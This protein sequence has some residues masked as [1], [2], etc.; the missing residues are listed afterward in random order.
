LFYFASTCWPKEASDI[1][2]TIKDVM[3][4]TVELAVRFS[5]RT[6]CKRCSTGAYKRRFGLL[7]PLPI[8]LL[9]YICEITSLSWK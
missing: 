1:V 8:W 2:S 6:Q 3:P 5:L 9:V 7:S 4:L